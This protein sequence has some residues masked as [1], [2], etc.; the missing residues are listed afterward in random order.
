MTRTVKPADV[1]RSEILDA[2][3]ALFG[4]R[5]YAATSVDEI[6]R[7]LGVAKGTFYYHF[8]SKEDVLTALA[9]RMVDEMAQRSRAVAEDRTLG[10]IEKLRAI[11]AEQRRVR[12]AGSSVVED[13]HRPENR[14][15]H[16]RSNVETVRVFGPILADVV[17]EGR[18][19][20]VFHLDDPLAT[21]QFVLAGSLFLFGEGV[22]DWTPEEAVARIRAMVT[23]VER[24]LGA[25]PGSFE[26][27][28]QD[29]LHE[30]LLG[31]K[32]PERT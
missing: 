8:R 12:A 15:L 32:T 6:V 4:A 31:I 5:G 22:F 25:A 24:A 9:W 23:L 28:L 1:R 10:A 30:N 20:G 13:L 14:E 7:E 2:A 16:D 17:E 27:L 3:A 11:F 29:A 26:G 21:T 19:A 18:Q